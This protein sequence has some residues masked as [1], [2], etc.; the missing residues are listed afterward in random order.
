M[1]GVKSDDDD[2]DDDDCED[3]DDDEAEE[4]EDGEDTNSKVHR[5]PSSSFSLGHNQGTMAS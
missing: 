1:T 4:E 5:F 3:D 2:D